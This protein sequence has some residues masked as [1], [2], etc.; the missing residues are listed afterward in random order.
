MSAAR[1]ELPGSVKR[2]MAAVHEWRP[3]VV[4]TDFEPLSGIYARSAHVPLVCV[5]NIHAIDRLRHD[6]E[7]V[8]GAREDFR[9]A[10]A[11]TRERARGYVLATVAWLEL[12]LVLP[13]SLAAIYLDGHGP[14]LC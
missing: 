14:I 5:D 1:R 3:D 7:I 6:A 13:G 10:W 9:L 12:L 2:W 11:L 8:Q 4:V